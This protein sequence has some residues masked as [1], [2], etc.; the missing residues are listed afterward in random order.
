MSSLENLKTQLNVTPATDAERAEFV[1]KIEYGQEIND[2][3]FDLWRV[4]QDLALYRRT[5]ETYWLPTAL[6][7]R[8][9]LIRKIRFMRRIL[10]DVTALRADDGA[11]GW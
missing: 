6:E 7:E 2:L 11:D 4:R 3:E 8:N 5:K 1:L 10:A 9:R